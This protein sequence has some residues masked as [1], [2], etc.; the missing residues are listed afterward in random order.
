MAQNLGCG[1]ITVLGISWHYRVIAVPSLFKLQVKELQRRGDPNVVIALAGNKA[2]MRDRRQVE[3]EV[4][5]RLAGL[6][7]GGEWD[8]HALPSA[9]GECLR[10]GQ[11]HPLS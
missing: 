3:A 5:H 11:W 9:G 4:C 8:T 7:P 6:I 2:D 10:D 1:R